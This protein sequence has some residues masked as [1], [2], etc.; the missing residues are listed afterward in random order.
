MQEERFYL[1][2]KVYSTCQKNKIQK[3][4]GNKISMI[5]QEPM[6]SLNPVFT[7]GDQIME[8]IILHQK[9]SEKE[10]KEKAIEMLKLTVYHHQKEGLRS[11]H[12]NFQVE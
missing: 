8:S 5:F 10:A 4:R 3:I 11:T 7:C 1:M 12:I 9:L 2:V 6:T